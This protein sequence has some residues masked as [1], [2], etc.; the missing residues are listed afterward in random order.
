MG[1]DGYTVDW[2]GNLENIPDAASWAEKNGSQI[3]AEIMKRGREIG[4]QGAGIF[5]S[6]TIREFLLWLN[7]P[8]NRKANHSA[9]RRYVD[10]PG[11]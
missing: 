3:F 11:I 9:R 6:Q 5:S 1:L 4:G 10:R 7:L 8:E 2:N